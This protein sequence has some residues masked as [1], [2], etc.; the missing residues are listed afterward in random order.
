MRTRAAAGAAWSLWA[1]GAALGASGL[2]L[3]ALSDSHYIPNHNVPVPAGAGALA[4]ADV[5]DATDFEVRLLVVFSIV[6]AAGAFIAARRPH[7]PIGWMLIGPGIAVGVRLFADGC[8]AY[9][10]PAHMAEPLPLAA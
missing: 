5:A 4:P 6:A 3:W 8:A 1:F 2:L 7:N 9:A 10:A